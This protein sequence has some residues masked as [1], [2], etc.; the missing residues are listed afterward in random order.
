MIFHQPVG[1]H[2]DRRKV[3]DNMLREIGMSLEDSGGK[4]TF[5]GAEPIRKTTMK[6][7]AAPA[8]TMTIGR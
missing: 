4:V 2:D 3:A 8:R 1:N 6:T 5:S 7:G